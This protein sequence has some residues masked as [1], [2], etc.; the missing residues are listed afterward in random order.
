MNVL[1]DTPPRLVVIAP[2]DRNNTPASAA[3]IFHVR[4]HYSLLQTI[5]NFEVYRAP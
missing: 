2:H 1:R 4:E 5:G 3:I